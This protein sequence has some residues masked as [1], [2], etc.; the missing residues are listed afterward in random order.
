MAAVFANG[1]HLSSADINE[2]LKT[3]RSLYLHFSVVKRTHI[4]L[5]AYWGKPLQ[6][7]WCQQLLIGVIY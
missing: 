1:Y 7:L 2:V 6:N 3:H 4:G 5:K